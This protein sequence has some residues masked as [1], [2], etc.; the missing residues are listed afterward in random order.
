[1]GGIGVIDEGKA[2]VMWLDDEFHSLYA[3]A[4]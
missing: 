3:A 2:L 4:R 1:M